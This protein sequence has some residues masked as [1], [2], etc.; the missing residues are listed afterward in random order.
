MGRTSDTTGHE[1]PLNPHPPPPTPFL[2][3][4]KQQFYLNNDPFYL[5]LWNFQLYLAS[6]QLQG[7]GTAQEGREK[8]TWYHEGSTAG[9]QGQNVKSSS[10]LAILL[11]FFFTDRCAIWANWNSCIE[12]TKNG[13]WPTVHVAALNSIQF[14]ILKTLSH[15]LQ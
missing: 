13:N 6:E 3:L 9:K 14:Q 7:C 5:T 1:C 15:L 4:Q 8:C 12:T 2:K 11:S 10:K